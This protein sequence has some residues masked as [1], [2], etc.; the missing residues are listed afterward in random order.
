MFG[1]KE[2]KNKIEITEKTVECPVKGC[3]IKVER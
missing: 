1:I 2:M 3:T